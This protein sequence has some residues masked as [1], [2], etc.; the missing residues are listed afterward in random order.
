MK[1]DYFEIL[2]RIKED[3]R[4][5]RQLAKE[6]NFSLGK[7]NYC[8]VELKKKG[9]IKFQ[10]LKQNPSKIRYALTPKGISLRTKLTINFMQ[11][12]LKEYEELKRELGGID[13]L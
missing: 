2:R 6:L 5:Q 9:L 8:L 11:R 10:S 4:N 7:L 13:N 1:E 12:K 3:F